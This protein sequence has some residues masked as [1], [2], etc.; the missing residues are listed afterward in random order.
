[1]LVLRPHHLLCIHGYIGHGYDENFI[2]NMDKIVHM[3]GDKSLIKII[4][5]CD[6]ICTA[7]P[8]KLEKGNCIFQNKVSYLDTCVLKILN[9]EYNNIYY[10]VNIVKT[11]KENLTS[12]KFKN[13]CYTCQWFPYGYCKKGLF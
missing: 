13:T 4:N 3:L 9:I 11:I 6:D 5:S 7:C 10:Y 12:E 2:K 1:M 8:N